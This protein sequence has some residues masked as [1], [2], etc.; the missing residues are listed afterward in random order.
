VNEK[1]DQGEIGLAYATRK[2]QAT[3][4]YHVLVVPQRQPRGDWSNRSSRSSPARPPGSSRSPRQ[5]VPAVARDRWLRHR[6]DDPLERR[7][8]FGRLT[9]DDAFLPATENAMLAPA[10][11]PLPSSSLGGRVDTYNGGLKLTARRWPG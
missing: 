5:P 1:L 10:V 11:L 7:L 6:A 2:L 9:Q 3:L 4:S 8:A